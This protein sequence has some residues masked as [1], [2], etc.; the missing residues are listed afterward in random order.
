M[1]MVCSDDWSDMSEAEGPKYQVYVDNNFHYLDES[2]RYLAGSYADC[3]TALKKCV[4]IVE[5]SLLNEYKPGMSE[6]ELVDR[7]KSFGEDP[8]ISSPHDECRFSAWEY[9]E[10]RAKVICRNDER[11]GL[12]PNHVV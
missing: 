2:E 8:W 10:R 5:N 11:Q 6:R 4:E 7:Y 3:E 12:E 1:K 9:A